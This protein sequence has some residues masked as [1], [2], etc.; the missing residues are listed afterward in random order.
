[1]IHL[2]N[3]SKTYR[4]RDGAFHALKNIN[5]H[6]KAGE[7]VSIIGQ[8]GAGKSTLVRL[9][10]LLERPSQGQVVVNNQELTTLSNGELRRTRQQIGMIFQ[11]FNLLSS[12]N[13]FD[14]IALP[15]ELNHTP[16][17]V[18][19]QKVQNLLALTGLSDKRNAYPSAL[20]GGQRQRV[21]IARALAA[22]PNILLCDEATSALDPET[23]RSILALLKDLQQ[24]LQLTLVMITHDLEV[25]KQISDQVVVLHAGE[26]VE[27]TSVSDLFL[28][29]Q[30]DAAKKLIG[31]KLTEVLHF[32]QRNNISAEVLGYVARTA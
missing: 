20:S 17:A 14:N 13:V 29:P 26:I 7:T 9:I 22:S 10:N 24:Q 25:V 11:H 8:S 31:D 15:L 30:S 19:Q 2:K 21:A 4:T 28:S 5:L 1:M 18:I 3:I 12:R 6:I 16:R 27:R 23:T 32:L